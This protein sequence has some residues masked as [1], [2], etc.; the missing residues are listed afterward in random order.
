MTHVNYSGYLLSYYKRIYYS[1]KGK[2]FIYYMIIES[3]ADPDIINV[4]YEEYE[5]IPYEP[6]GKGGKGDIYGGLLNDNV[7]RM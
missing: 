7:K 3:F 1:S 6:E 2:E 5:D 4:R